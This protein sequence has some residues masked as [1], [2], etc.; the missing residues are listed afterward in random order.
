[1]IHL[2]A[3]TAAAV[4][5]AVPGVDASAVTAVACGRLHV[6]ISEHAAPP[7]ASRE[8]ALEHAST[9]AAVAD[10]TPSV[11]VRFGVTH[12]AIDD[13]RATIRGAEDVLLGMLARIG[14]SVEYVVRAIAPAAAPAAVTVPEGPPEGRGRRFLEQRLAAER[15][16]TTARSSLAAGIATVTAPLAAR[17]SE[18]VDRDGATGP[19]RCF[20]VARVASEPFAAA[21]ATALAER[22]D[23]LVAGPWP[24][25]TFADV[26]IGG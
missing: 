17:A 14:T 4:D 10:L 21:A 7:P 13:L 5:V 11:P 9:V 6:V 18:V 20:L 2:Y 25:Y 22:D 1:M 3:L 23:L 12:A 16:A 26:E 8:R 19:E 15:A 24:P